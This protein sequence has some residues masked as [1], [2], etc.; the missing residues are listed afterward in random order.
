MESGVPTCGWFRAVAAPAPDPD[1]RD[2]EN[3]SPS[4]FVACFFHELTWFGCT[5]CF[6]VSATRFLNS[7]VNRRL[8]PVI[9]CLPKAWNTP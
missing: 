8:L 4:P 9:P 2:V 3:T 1:F 5:S 6:A 7:A